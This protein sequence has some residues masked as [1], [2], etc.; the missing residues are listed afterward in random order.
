M[1][2]KTNSAGNTEIVVL[3]RHTGQSV[4]QQAARGR[5]ELSKDIRLGMD[6]LASLVGSQ[7]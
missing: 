3:V 5:E 6:S 4:H 1:E 2:G 7:K